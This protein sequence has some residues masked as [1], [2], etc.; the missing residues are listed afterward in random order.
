MFGVSPAPGERRTVCFI[1]EDV[2]SIPTFQM[3]TLR[4]SLGSVKAPVA[5][6]SGG[7]WGL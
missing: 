3:E 6:A 1:S 5:V 4:L 2:A 7:P